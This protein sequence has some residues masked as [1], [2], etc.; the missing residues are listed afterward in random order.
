MTFDNGPH[1]Q[2]SPGHFPPPQGEPVPPPQG[3]PAPQSHPGQV[4]LPPPEKKPTGNKRNGWL[5]IFLGAMFVLLGVLGF[6]D[7]SRSA[8]FN[9]LFI[10]LGVIN[11]VMG[12]RAVIASKRTI[13]PFAPDQTGGGR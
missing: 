13:D 1:Q 3:Q 8:V 9:W 5:Y 12:V 11:A 2:G 4:P 6:V 10:G 7:D